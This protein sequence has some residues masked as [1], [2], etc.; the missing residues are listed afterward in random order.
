MFNPNINTGNLNAVN[1]KISNLNAKNTEIQGILNVNNNLVSITNADKVGIKNKEPNYTLDVVGDINYT[2]NLLNNGNIV[3]TETY[4]VNNLWSKSGT[5]VYYQD[6]VIVGGNIQTS[7][8]FYVNGTSYFLSDMVCGGTITILNLICTNNFQ[9]LNASIDNLTVVKTAGFTCDINIPNNNILVNNITG[10]NILLTGNLDMSLGKLKCRTLEVTNFENFASTITFGQNIVVL[11]K[12]YLQGDVIVNTNKFQINSATGDTI[13]AG[14]VIIGNALRVA[15]TLT[16][17]NETSLNKTTVHNDLTVNGNMVCTGNLSLSKSDGTFN[18]MKVNLDLVTKNFYADTTT[19]STNANVIIN[20]TTN[21]TKPFWVKYTTASTSTS[22]GSFVVG[23]GVGVG[24]DLWVNGTIRSLNGTS[25]FRTIT[26][27]D[28]I[29]CSGAMVTTLDSSFQNNLQVGKNLQVGESITCKNIVASQVGVIPALNAGIITTTSNIT[30]GGNLFVGGLT[31]LNNSVVAAGGFQTNSRFIKD[32]P[33]IYKILPEYSGSVFTIQSAGSLRTV[34]IPTPQIGLY[35]KI[36]FGPNYT[37]PVDPAFYL[38]LLG[39]A[40]PSKF[41]LFGI[42]N[43]GSVATTITPNT[44]QSIKISSAKPGDV[45]EITS[46]LVQDVTTTVST[47]LAYHIKIIASGTGV[48]VP[49]NQGPYP[50]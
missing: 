26:V 16:V 39:P 20:P 49:T 25:I 3:Q 1:A 46:S 35:F 15:N 31:T 22:T 2:G 42:I 28:L 8:K 40:I 30:C 37:Q 4:S 50:R 19:T 47:D 7:Y 33:G 12:S 13:I 44:F 18:T 5:Y 41:N 6:N 29:T 48:Y 17:I 23:G 10:K 24:G 14:G 21:P 38:L 27:S 32:A 45:I 9:T 11:G 36:V 34:G 43:T